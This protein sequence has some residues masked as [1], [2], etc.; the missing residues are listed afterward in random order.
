LSGLTGGTETVTATGGAAGSRPALA[1]R[2][3]YWLV[4]IA[5]LVVAMAAAYV[6]SMLHFTD[7]HLSPP[8][9]DTLIYFQYARQIAHRQPMIYIDGDPATSG[10]TSFLYPFVLAVGY[11]AGFREQHLVIFGLACATASMLAAAYMVYA[12][13]RAH[14]GVLAGGTAA[15]LLAMNGWLGWTFFSIM[16]TSVHAMSVLAGLLVLPLAERSGRWLA[17][18]CA[19]LFLMPFVRPELAA[20]A[21]GIALFWLLARIIE[22]SALTRRAS[23]VAP[24]I[25][26]AA[27]AALYFAMMDWLTGS[28]RTDTYVAKSVLAIPSATLDYK[29]EHVWAAFTDNTGFAFEFFGPWYVWV[30][31]ALMA[32]V[33]G[34]AWALEDLRARRLTVRILIP[35][36][37]LGGIATSSL[38]LFA[39]VHHHR[40]A[41]A[42]EPLAVLLVVRGVVAVADWLPSGRRYAWL[43]APALFA[44]AAIPAGQWV[45]EYGR[46]TRD[47]YF[48][49][50]Q[51]AYWIREN[52]PPDAVIGLHD[53][54]AIPYYGRRRIY[55]VAGLVT[56]Q[57]VES[58]NEGTAS[59]WERIERLPEGDRPTL[60]AMYPSAVFLGPQIGFVKP[61]MSWDIGIATISAYRE[62]F[63]YEPD[64]T[65]LGSGDEPGELPAGATSW[66]VIDRVDVADIQSE[67]EHDYTARKYL[68]FT[69][70]FEVMK[71]GKYAGQARRVADGGRLNDMESFGFSAQPGKPYAVLMRVSEDRATTLSI[72]HDGQT[73]RVPIPAGGGSWHDVVIAR[74]E[75]AGSDIPI[76][77]GANGQRYG[78]YSYWLIQP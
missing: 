14:A 30:A 17:A 7:G 67:K 1:A 15:V 66:R 34:I 8:L 72:Y 74:G 68:P 25:T 51:A 73:A 31:A 2:E 52:T 63:M 26:A 20:I 9:D 62:M 75:S 56:Q 61:G 24:L 76:Q 18:L 29:V 21:A 19:L 55:D 11:A 42:Y 33:G 13:G 35:L 27:G 22:G 36:L 53:A 6:A 59:S 3:W 43:A 77:I 5:A 54:G 4:S 28:P 23:A 39:G 12:I 58:W 32:L 16:E 78:S 57:S 49:Q 38:Q 50:T 41:A 70:T 64:N 40:H 44:L 47:I 65:L 37:F 48:Q 46:N 10:S 71:T 45:R 60:Y 69:R